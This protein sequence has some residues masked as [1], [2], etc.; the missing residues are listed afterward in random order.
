MTLEEAF[1]AVEPGIEP[2][3]ARILVQIKTTKKTSAGGIVLVEESKET[4]KWN[5]QV[6]K[7]VK[8]GPLAFCNRETKQPWPEGMW[9]SVGDYI[10]VPRWGG[11]RFEVATGKKYTVTKVVNGEKV[12]LEVD[13]EPALFVV[14]NDHEAI[15]KITGDPLTMKNFFL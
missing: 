11:D 13:E 6:A 15:A 3:G 14:F 7:V 8:L 12:D 5:T 10:R 2:L 4:E 1:P 9:A